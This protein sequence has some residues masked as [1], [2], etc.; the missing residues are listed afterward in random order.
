MDIR[1]SF[2]RLKKKVKHMGSKQKPGR[3]GA[4]VDR[5]SVDPGNPLPR[6]EPHVVAD[7]GEGN[8][9]DDDGQQVGPTDQPPQPDEPELVSANGGKIDQGEG[10]V[11]VDWRKVTPMYSQP[12]QDVEVGAGSGPCREGEEDGKIYPCLSAPSIPHSGEHN[13]ALT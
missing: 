1:N 10:E 6:S 11:D 5:E 7:D 3:T 2:S 13:G 9:V 4:D 12:H 8:G